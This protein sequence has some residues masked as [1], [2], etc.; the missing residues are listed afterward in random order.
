MSVLTS[1]D[2]SRSNLIQ[3]FIDEALSS[4]LGEEIEGAKTRTMD[5]STEKGP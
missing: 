1:S 2:F 3:S 4:M 5:A